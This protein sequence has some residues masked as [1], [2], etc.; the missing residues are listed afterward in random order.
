MKRPNKAVFLDRDGTII[1]DKHYLKN[2]DDIEL[3]EGA[4]QALAD[5]ARLGYLLVII[6]NQSGI[7][8]GFFTDS[9]VQLQHDRLRLLLEQF[10]VRLASIKYCPH[11]P[12]DKCLCRKPSPKLIIDAAE[13]LS[14]DCDK[15]FMIGDKDCDIIAGLKADCKTI[16]IG[17]TTNGSATY[18]VKKISEVAELLSKVH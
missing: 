7:G 14:I 16:F 10:N 6:T 18:S 4:G 2:A 3:T 13:E 15:S 1:T 5:M 8:R 11:T 9:H 17:K 12:E